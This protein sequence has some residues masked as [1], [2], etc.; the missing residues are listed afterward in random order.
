MWLQRSRQL[1]LVIVIEDLHW[2]DATS[3]ELFGLLAEIVAGWLILLVWTSRQGYRPPW[4]EKSYAT[5]MALSPLAPDDSVRVLRSM[6]G[7]ERVPDALANQIVARAEGNPLFLEELVRTVR[8]QAA[9]VRTLGVPD[10]VQDV[11]RGR[12]DRLPSTA[13]PTPPTPPAASR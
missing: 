8:E 6:L 1:P 5:Q 11:L 7:A 9:N 13:N 12:M 2:I 10:T 4:V 3:E